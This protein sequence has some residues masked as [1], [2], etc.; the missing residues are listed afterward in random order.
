[1]ARIIFCKGESEP[2]LVDAAMGETLMQ[3]AK[4]DGVDGIE[5]ECG[6]SMVCGT[7]H[8]YIAEP[9]FSRLAAPSAM[10]ADMLDCS[11]H[12]QPNSRLSC[13]LV[14]DASMEGMMVFLPASQR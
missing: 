6:G 13:Q 12:P 3:A 14:V 7:C 11:L 9:W 5:A 4:A 1:V 10:E 8:V 2:H